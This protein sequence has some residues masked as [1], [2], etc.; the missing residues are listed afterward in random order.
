MDRFSMMC[1]S[2]EWRRAGQERGLWTR[3]AFDDLLGLHVDQPERFREVLERVRPEVLVL[4]GDAVQREHLYAAA[5]YGGIR[6][7]QL[8]FCRRVSEGDLRAF[9]AYLAEIYAARRRK[10]H[11]GAK[12]STQLSKV[13]ILARQI[14]SRGVLEAFFDQIPTVH[15][16]SCL[17]EPEPRFGFGFQS[18]TVS[19]KRLLTGTRGEHGQ[20]LFVLEKLGKCNPTSIRMQPLFV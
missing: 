13:E 5:D 6:E 10:D 19:T 16:V 9:S 8:H 17:I 18:S 3:V 15:Q 20:A 12:N 4:K 14:V 7:L 2:R 1:V 11:D